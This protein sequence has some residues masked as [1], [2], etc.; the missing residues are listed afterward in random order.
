MT[1]PSKGTFGRSSFK[2]QTVP[3]LPK[4]AYG[5]SQILLGDR[6]IR[7]FE[8]A[9]DEAAEYLGYMVAHDPK[10]VGRPIIESLGQHIHDLIHNID[11]MRSSFSENDELINQGQ[12]EQ[13][14][15][16]AMLDLGAFWHLVKLNEE[17]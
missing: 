9:M 7:S 13:S 2:P 15:R 1:I 17:G 10:A 8:A 3:G 12:F 16:R 5:Y 4:P 6:N 14:M 11:K